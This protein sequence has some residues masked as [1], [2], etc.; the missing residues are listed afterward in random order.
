MTY[1]QGGLLHRLELSPEFQRTEYAGQVT[2]ELTDFPAWSANGEHL[3]YLSGNKLKRLARASGISDDITPSLPWREQAPVGQ[4]IV[5]AGRLYTGTSDDY[6][7]NQDIVLEGAR[8]VAISPADPTVVPDLDASASTVVPGLFEMHAH[9]GETSEVQGR[10]W[11]SHG[12]TSVRD[13]G[14]NPYTAKERQEAWDSQ[15]RVGPRTHITGYLTDGNR[16]YYAMAEGVVSDAHLDHVLQRAHWLE[17][18]FIKTYVRLPDHQQ[19]RVID[20]AHRHGMS[21]SSHEIY[22]AIAYGSDHVEHIGGTSRRGY[23]PKVSRLGYSY[24]D[25]IEMLSVGNMGITATAVLPGSMVIVQEEPD[26]FETRQFD[27]FYGPATRRQYEG[28]VNLFGLGADA[29][30]QANGGL[31]R[32]LTERDALLVTGTDAPFVPYGAG[33]HAEFRL[34]ARAGVSARDILRQA[35]LKSAQAAGVADDLGTL[36]VGKLADMVVVDGDPLNEIRDLDRVRVTVKHG[37]IYPL[38]ELLKTP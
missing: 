17:L 12:I 18:D 23:Q 31:L 19:R 4:R 35:T 8:I 10:I 1:L 2:D 3:V 15:R 14:S 34:Y 38:E 7:L 36:E 9:M 24:Q 27:H 30:A 16:V 25:V 6:L 33:L 5:R 20:F 21:V 26:W 13:P 11:L 28:M 29:T 32:A 22:P 37:V